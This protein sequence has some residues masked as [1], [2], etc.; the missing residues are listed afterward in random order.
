[1]NMQINRP[2]RIEN[3]GGFGYI[4]IKSSFALEGKKVIR[5]IS[6]VNT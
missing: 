1:M 3:P 6:L 5:G 2:E 4:V